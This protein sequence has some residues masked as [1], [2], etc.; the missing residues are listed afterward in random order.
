MQKE[1]ISQIETLGY[2][3]RLYSAHTHTVETQ[4]PLFKQFFAQTDSSQ[5]GTGII[6]QTTWVIQLP[7][8]LC[9]IQYPYIHPF[10]VM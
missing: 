3:N 1:R 9:P 2:T 7:L 4:F 10:N 6:K 8:S 5:P